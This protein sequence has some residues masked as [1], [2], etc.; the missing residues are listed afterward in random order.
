MRRN[1]HQYKYF[2]CNT[3]IGAKVANPSVL[4]P[5]ISNSITIDPTGNYIF[6]AHSVTPFI[7]AYEW[8]RN[9][10]WC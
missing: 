2:S 10:I 5:G 1:I 7:T 6:V 8:T 3:R 9:W 4:P